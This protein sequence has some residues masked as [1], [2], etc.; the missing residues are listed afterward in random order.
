MASQHHRGA[1]FLLV[2]LGLLASL[3]QAFVVVPNPSQR[4]QQQL[5][6]HR[7]AAAATVSSRAPRIL[8]AAA[9]G[10]DG[11]KKKRG[12][13]V[14]RALRTFLQFNGPRL[15]P[16][17]RG[18]APAVPPEEA[19]AVVPSMGQ[20]LPLAHGVVLVTGAT[21]GVGKRIVELLLKKG[22]RVRALARNKQKAL[23]MLNKGQ[24]PEKGARLEIVQADVSDAKQLPASVMEGVVA[25]V[26]ATA[27]IVQPKAGDTEDRARYYQGIVFY[28]P[29]TGAWV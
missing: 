17:R 27:A 8:L 10:E 25:V 2:I 24:E 5:K 21:G 22:L 29:E 13:P 16:R 11:G 18:S 6:Q 4:Q 7:G 3:A 14:G 26:A 12:W 28:E 9:D 15:F 20:G 23:A 19:G 1:A